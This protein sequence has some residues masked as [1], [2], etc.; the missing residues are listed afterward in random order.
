[1]SMTINDPINYL[2]IMRTLIDSDETGTNM[3]RIIRIVLA[4][5]PDT[6]ASLADVATVYEMTTSQADAALSAMVDMGLAAKEA[7]VSADGKRPIWGYRLTLPHRID[8]G[9]LDRHEITND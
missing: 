7:A 1:M 9:P 6:S 5:L 8:T 3:K 2:K 4:P